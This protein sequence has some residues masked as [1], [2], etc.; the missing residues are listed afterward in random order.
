MSPMDQ[1]YVNSVAW[2][3]HGDLCLLPH[4]FEMGTSAGIQ[5]RKLGFYANGIFSAAVP[6][7]S[8]DPGLSI[9]I[10]L[11]CDGGPNAVAGTYYPGSLCWL[12]SFA[13]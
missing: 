9:Q 13:S 1:S 7:L 8:N 2:T 4:S 11:E 3:N 5:L 6:V 12:L 10:F